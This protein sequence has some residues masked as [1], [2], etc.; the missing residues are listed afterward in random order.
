MKLFRLGQSTKLNVWALFTS[1]HE[2]TAYEHWKVSLPG[3]GNNGDKSQKWY[4]WILY[5]MRIIIHMVMVWCLCGNMQL[6][7]VLAETRFW[8]T[9]T[10]QTSGANWHWR[11]SSQCR[12]VPRRP[13]EKRESSLLCSVGSPTWWCLSVLYFAFILSQPVLNDMSAE[14]VITECISAFA[15]LAVPYHIHTYTYDVLRPVQSSAWCRYVEISRNIPVWAWRE[16]LMWLTGVV[17]SKCWLY[18]TRLNNKSQCSQSQ[19]NKHFQ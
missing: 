7:Y 1:W 14:A 15:G 9:R 12:R 2:P 19:R 3:W 13:S 8:V 18:T 6:Y 11:S 4:L 16:G 5:I 10:C 17:V